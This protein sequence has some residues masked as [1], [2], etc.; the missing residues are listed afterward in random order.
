MGP[1]DFTKILPSDLPFDPIPPMIEPDRDI[2]RK[3]ILSKFEEDCIN[4]EAPRLLLGF[5]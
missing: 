2:S 4:I 3:N 5:Y 1:K